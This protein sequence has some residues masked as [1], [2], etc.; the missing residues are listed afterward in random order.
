ML[1]V[2]KKHGDKLSATEILALSAYTVG[3]IIAMQDQRVMKP[4]MAMEIVASNIEL[5]NQHVIQEL[6]NNSNGSA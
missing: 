3:Q 1:A 2:L 6:A 4:G 5:G